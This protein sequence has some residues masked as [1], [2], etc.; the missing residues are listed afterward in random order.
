MHFQCFFLTFYRPYY[1]PMTCIGLVRV[2][3]VNVSI[4]REVDISEVKSE[5]KYKYVTDPELKYCEALKVVI[6]NHRN[7]LL[8]LLN[9]EDIETIFINIEDILQVFNFF[10]ISAF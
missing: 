4:W 8:N 1:Q 3:F 7:K 2:A 5:N 10:I 6:E 9:A